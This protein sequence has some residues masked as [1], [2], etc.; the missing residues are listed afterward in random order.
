MYDVD[1]ANVKALRPSKKTLNILACKAT[2]GTDNKTIILVPYR[3]DG[4]QNR[5]DQL[6]A[7]LKHYK[8]IPVLVIEQSNDGKKF[9]RGALLNIGYDYCV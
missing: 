2:K 1:P 6:D 3:D 7:F 9:N 5:A 4:N 8:N